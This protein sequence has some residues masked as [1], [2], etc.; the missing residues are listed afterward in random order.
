[1]TSAP[2]STAERSVRIAALGLAAGAAASVLGFLRIASWRPLR[3]GWTVHPAGPPDGAW[4]SAWGP[5]ARSAWW[6]ADHALAAAMWTAAGLAVLVLAAGLLH[7]LLASLSRVTEHDPEW[8]LRGAVGATRRRVRGDLGRDGLLVAG[9]GIA[10]GLFLGSA[11]GALLRGVAPAG[12][13][14]EGGRPGPGLPA[15][16]ILLLAGALVAGAARLFVPRADLLRRPAR[17]LA[18]LAD[19]ATG[20]IGDTAVLAGPGGLEGWL[21]SAAQVA[22]AIV[23][24]VAAVLLARSAPRA[25]QAAGDLLYAHDTLVLR[26]TLGP[27]ADRAAAW[28]AVR[29]R[30]RGLPGVEDAAVASPGAFLGLGTVDRVAAECPGCSLPRAPVYFGRARHMAVGPGYFAVLGHPLAIGEMPDGGL[31]VDRTFVGRLLPGDPIGRRVWETGKPAFRGSGLAVTAVTDLPPPIGL[32]ERM[33]RVFLSAATH[34]PAVADVAVRFSRGALAGDPGAGSRS[35]LERDTAAAIGA[36]APVG[37][38]RT[39][40]TLAGLLRGSLEPARWLGRTIAA[41]AL[42]GL[43]LAFGSVARTLHSRVWARRA[44]FGLRRAVGARRREVVRLALED[45][46]TL[47]LAGG[48]GGFVL[49]AGV[50]RGLP[51]LAGGLEPLPLGLLA[52]VAGVVALLGAA[53]ALLAVRRILRLQPAELQGT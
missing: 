3:L 15:L 16:A 41:L 26:V 34:P 11:G 5:T 52:A 22:V 25:E 49:G 48:A 43:L 9:A 47:S 40:G 37:R 18:E 23:V 42:V 19:P 6:V 1:M 46:R 14:F 36:A 12:L 28:S 51:L 8:A 45:A 30:L 39:L 53:A 32:G 29:E 21:L 2:G 31:V 4:T 35:R 24:G 50:D 7:L 13:A 38:I 20:G 10:L 27:D 44:E 17:R 33:P